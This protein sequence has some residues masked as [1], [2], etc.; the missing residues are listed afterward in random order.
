MTTLRIRIEKENVTNSK[1]EFRILM[2][3]TGQPPAIAR[4]HPHV[5]VEKTTARGA[6]LWGVAERRD[7]VS[8]FSL[9]CF[10]IYGVKSKSGHD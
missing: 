3:V 1:I 5:E 9:V 6:P 4:A 2:C 8:V 10:L 7:C